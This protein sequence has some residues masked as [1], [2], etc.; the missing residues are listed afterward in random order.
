MTSKGAEFL[1]RLIQMRLTHYATS[2]NDDV[3]DFT[4][5]PSVGG[6]GSKERRFAMAKSVRIGEKRLLK[7]VEEALAE[8]FAREGSAPK[9]A[10]EVD[11]EGDVEMGGTGKKQ[12]A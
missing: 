1:Y 2:L 8:K 11:E 4:A 3:R 7:Q 9:R 12:R 6:H 10:R 5:A